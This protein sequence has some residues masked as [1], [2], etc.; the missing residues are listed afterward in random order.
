MLLEVTNLNKK[1]NGFQLKDFNLSMEKGYITG[2]VGKNGAGK[3]TALKCIL[4][5]MEAD[6]GEIKIFGKDIDGNARELKN[7]IGIVIGDNDFFPLKKVKDITGIYKGFYDKWDDGV[8]HNYLHKFGIDENKRIK[9]LSSGMKVK[10]SLTLALS[11]NAEL[12]IFDEPTSGLDPVARDEVTDIFREIV[13]DGEKSILFSTHI[14]SD[15]DKCAD[16]VV[17]IRDGEIT[18][19]ESKDDFIAEYTLI[20]GE[21]GQLGEDLK[22]RLIGQKVN[23]F[24]W[25]GLLKTKDL[26]E[27]DGLKRAVPNIEDI[28]VYYETEERGK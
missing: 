7:K 6:S 18:E 12:F 26:K 23:S 3:T 20:A 2:F 15:L 10:Y 4:G 5:F 14:T 8:Y 13:S 28:M 1:L 19:S 27:T 16:Y 22:S 17:Y 25:T 11:H 21:I 9:E 24:G